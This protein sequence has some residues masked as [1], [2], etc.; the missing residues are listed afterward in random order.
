MSNGSNVHSND[1]AL[2]E[3]LEHFRYLEQ[4]REEA[5]G[6][7]EKKEAKPP[8]QSPWLRTREARD[9]LGMSIDVVGQ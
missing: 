5:R 6:M 2:L 4:V 9:Y 8:R 7:P 3:Q 1:R